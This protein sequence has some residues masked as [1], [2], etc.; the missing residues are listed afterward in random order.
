M[1]YILLLQINDFLMGFGKMFFEKDL[2][3]EAKIE[4]LKKKLN[5]CLED[6][7]L[8]SEKILKLST[9]LDKLIAKYYSQ[10]KIL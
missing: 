5:S 9:R 2:V 7:D 6:D 4:N 10:K 3:L 1:Q 8:D